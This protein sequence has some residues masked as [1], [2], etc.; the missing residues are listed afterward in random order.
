[1]QQ[2]YCGTKRRVKLPFRSTGPQCLILAAFD[3]QTSMCFAVSLKVWSLTGC[4]L[5]QEAEQQ[6]V[7]KV[8]AALQSNEVDE[9]RL[10]EER[11][12]R[13]Q[14]ILAKHQQEQQADAGGF[15]PCSIDAVVQTTVAVAALYF[16]S[17]QRMC[18]H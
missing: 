10:I 11:R 2:I 3:V 9:D 14:E 7:A 13:R 6:F 18:T 1:M 5:Q 8:E 12:R 4:I 17:L 16:A 15:H